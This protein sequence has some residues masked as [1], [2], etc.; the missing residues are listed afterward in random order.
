MEL[1]ELMGE[2]CVKVIDRQKL[3]MGLLGELYE[4]WHIPGKAGISR[5]E[6][7]GNKAENACA[8]QYLEDKGYI[9]KRCVMVSEAPGAKFNHMILITS[10]G[11]DVYEEWLVKGK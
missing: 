5:K 3:R 4:A 8:Y 2:K 11:I 10:E 9:K 7:E 6:Y 1:K